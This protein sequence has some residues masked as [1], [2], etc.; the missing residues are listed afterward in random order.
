MGSAE[1]RQI[2]GKLARASE[3]IHGMILEAQG[4][5]PPDL[6]TTYEFVSD[7]KTCSMTWEGKSG[8]KLN[9]RKRKAGEWP[10]WEWFDSKGKKIACASSHSCTPPN[11]DWTVPQPEKK[12]S[13]SKGSPKSGKKVKEKKKENP[14]T[15]A[16][17]P[18]FLLADEQRMKNLMI[19]KEA[20]K[21]ADEAK[22]TGAVVT[23]S[24]A[25][26][27]HWEKLTTDDMV[28]KE[29]LIKAIKAIEMKVKGDSMGNEEE[30]DEKNTE[31]KEH[32]GGRRFTPSGK[33]RPTTKKAPRNGTEEKLLK[34]LDEA[35]LTAQRAHVVSHCSEMKSAI[36]LRI[37]L[38]TKI[39]ANA[40]ADEKKVNSLFLL[41]GDK[42]DK[43]VTEAAGRTSDRAMKGTASSPNNRQDSKEG[44]WRPVW[45]IED[46]VEETIPLTASLDRP[47]Q[48]ALN[49]Y[50]VRV[51]ELPGADFDYRLLGGGRNK[52]PLRVQRALERWLKRK[53]I[54]CG[55]LISS[56]WDWLR[57]EANFQ[58][59]SERPWRALQNFL[60]SQ[61]SISQHGYLSSNTI[62][63]LQEFLIRSGEYPGKIDGLWGPR[64]TKAFQCLLHKRGFYAGSC[65]GKLLHSTLTSMRAFFSKLGFYKNYSKN[66]FGTSDAAR[67]Q[68][69]L[70]SDEA[71]KILDPSCKLLAMLEVALAQARDVGIGESKV[72][73][74]LLEQRKRFVTIA[75]KIATQ[76]C[77]ELTGKLTNEFRLNSPETYQKLDAKENEETKRWAVKRKYGHKPATVK[78]LQLMLIKS[79][80]Q[81]LDAE[82]DGEHWD[83]TWENALVKFLCKGGY[84]KNIFDDHFG[85]FKNRHYL[86]ADNLERIL[87]LATSMQNDEKSLKAFKE[88]GKK[89]FTATFR[90][91]LMSGFTL[92]PR[93]SIVLVAV[94]FDVYYVL[95]KTQ[96]AI[97]KMLRECE[98]AL[99][100]PPQGF[101]TLPIWSQEMLEALL[102]D[103]T[104]KIKKKDGSEDK[105][106]SKSESKEDKSDQKY[107]TKPKSDA[108]R[109]SRGSKNNKDDYG[110]AKSKEGK[111]VDDGEGDPLLE[112]E[113]DDF[114]DNIEIPIAGILPEFRRFP[115]AK[116]KKENSARKKDP[117]LKFLA[118]IAKN[119]GNEDLNG[120][121]KRDGDGV[122]PVIWR[123]TNGAS[124]TY[125]KIKDEKGSGV[126][127]WSDSKGR[128]IAT[129]I[130]TN[131][132]VPVFDGNQW[133]GDKGAKEPF[134]TLEWLYKPTGCL[135][136]ML[137][138]DDTIR[139]SKRFEAHIKEDIKRA[140]EKRCELA[141]A[142]LRTCLSPNNLNQD[143]SSA[144]SF[145]HMAT[146][147]K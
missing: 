139:F 50:L 35:I 81:S 141:R 5:G 92:K 38:V 95:V 124:L 145:A 142:L 51:G 96:E 136:M 140:N 78:A 64:T 99:A 110:D 29:A 24:R 15:P 34:S 129:S 9:W 63:T 123:G 66:C 137:K 105:K 109:K 126:W 112:P 52:F 80:I 56:M 17:V 11:F 116:K 41:A 114:T 146:I 19:I 72:V 33:S 69:V 120:R 144:V 67:L 49:Q 22:L 61:R 36:T 133:E 118:L 125:K 2:K 130:R 13:A 1:S 20:L 79:G 83:D 113:D 14:P 40:L 7:P 18:K 111:D 76:K 107:K 62:R 97:R 101:F 132:E 25:V 106:K 88:A 16:K 147:I 8:A 45:R 39:C 87:A 82:T 47:T 128:R 100:A 46:R 27:A 3:R 4:D 30:P 77:N 10:V 94:K 108:K 32:K 104:V 138:L 134:P 103:P 43:K 12:P 58:P 91:G 48:S 74:G 37:T 85:G 98:T 55:S 42:H 143:E 71:D 89:M 84:Y 117:R 127:S 102:F 44:K 115:N 28:A 68:G 131:C 122:G 135:Q 6:S 93:E 59:Q 90:C 23:N 119:G 121:Y 86:L 75:V 73:K 31:K 60:N 70:Q 21:L 53:E 54:H 65:D 57:S 26:E